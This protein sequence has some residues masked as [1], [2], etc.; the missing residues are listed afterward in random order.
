MNPSDAKAEV[1]TRGS[2]GQASF[3]SLAELRRL[4]GVE[5]FK[6]PSELFQGCYK[7]CHTIVKWDLGQW[8]LG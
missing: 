4:H 3:L 2:A 8:L 6:G 7:R 1:P 5:T